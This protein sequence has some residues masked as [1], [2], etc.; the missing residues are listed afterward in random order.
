MG[1]YYSRRGNNLYIFVTGD[2]EMIDLKVFPPELNLFGAGSDWRVNDRVAII[3]GA[4]EENLDKAEIILELNGFTKSCLLY[5]S[6][7]PRDRTRSRMPS[8]A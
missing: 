4:G 6:P 2:D 5:T 7:S 1:R 3:G 8:S